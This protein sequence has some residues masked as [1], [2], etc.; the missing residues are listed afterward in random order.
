[1]KLWIA[2]GN[3]GKL[4]EFK[5][6][7]NKTNCEIHA[8]NELPFYASP[9]ET[10]KTFL[11]NARIKA[12]SLKSVVDENDW[13]LAD[14]SGLCVEGLN[15]LPGVHSARYAGEK[16]SDGEN[17]AKLL[18]MMQI[19]PM[20][21]RNAYFEC[22]LVLISPQREEHLFTGQVHGQIATKAL[23]TKGFGY[24]PIFIPQNYKE[25]FGELTD[26]VKNTLSHRAVACK[27][28][29]DFLLKG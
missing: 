14:D 13:V 16:A 22:S 25:T 28:L 17:V 12:K 1:M 5:L 3:K 23:G 29:T 27:K 9:P 26:A 2:T 8:Q 4:A 6:L 19:R 24:D 20:A 10:G 15:G 7:L 18:K 21:N 11:D